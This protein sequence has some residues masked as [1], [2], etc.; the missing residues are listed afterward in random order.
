MLVHFDNRTSCNINWTHLLCYFAIISFLNIKFWIWCSDWYNLDKSRRVKPFRCGEYDECIEKAKKHGSQKNTR[1]YPNQGKYVRREDAILHALEIERKAVRK[2]AADPPTSS[3]R[4][5]QINGVKKKPSHEIY[6]SASGERHRASRKRVKNPND[7]EEDVKTEGMLRM[8]DLTEIGSEKE[9][10]STMKSESLELALVNPNLVN[11]MNFQFGVGSFGMSTSTS[12]TAKRKRSNMA[13]AYEN[14]RK[15][16]K[17]V[18]LSK[19]C[20]GTR[21]IIPSYCDWVGPKASNKDYPMDMGINNKGTDS[22]ETS[23]HSTCNGRDSESGGVLGAV[24]ENAASDGFINVPLVMGDFYNGGN[25]IFPSLTIC[26][27]CCIMLVHFGAQEIGLF[28]IWT[29][30]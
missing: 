22:S 10:S 11:D 1:K 2:A 19:I 13:Q 8:R 6:K 26:W 29:S 15:K 18:P 27:L 28:L 14:M 3:A 12:L 24:L 30:V 21:V 7:S 5:R 17:S 4:P 25:F 23:S 20:D 16:Q 9:K